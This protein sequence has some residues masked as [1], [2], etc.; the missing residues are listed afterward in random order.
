MSKEPINVTRKADPGLLDMLGN[1]GSQ[2][3]TI[4]NNPVTTII[5]PTPVVKKY[6]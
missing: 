1:F 6:Y 2:I 4:F 3:Q 5:G